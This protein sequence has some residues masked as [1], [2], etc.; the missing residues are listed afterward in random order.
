M[1]GVV[2]ICDKRLASAR[3]FGN[4]G[5]RTFVTDERGDS[6]VDGE[7]ARAGDDV[8]AV[9][10]RAEDA[11]GVAE[12]ALVGPECGAGGEGWGPRERGRV[13]RGT[14]G[15]VRV[16]EGGDLERG[17]AARGGADQVREGDGEGCCGGAA[18][19]EAE[20]EGEEKAKSVERKG[21]HGKGVAAASGAGLRAKEEKKEAWLDLHV[22]GPLLG[23]RT[24][25]S[26]Y[27]RTPPV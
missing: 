15:V 3:F 17:A 12:L 1:C 16:E 21:E 8:L 5:Q 13:V 18:R 4:R 20:G 11:V 2:L 25:R 19:A 7:L 22:L 26:A 23:G 10:L 14:E 6:G 9:A 27:V 24:P